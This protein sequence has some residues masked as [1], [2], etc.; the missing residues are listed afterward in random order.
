MKSGILDHGWDALER[1]GE[2]SASFSQ[3]TEEK[4][5]CGSLELL[6]R[7]RRMQ[8]LLR[9]LEWLRYEEE[10]G[11][12]HIQGWH[13]SA[14]MH[15]AT[16]G[17]KGKMKGRYCQRAPTLHNLSMQIELWDQPVAFG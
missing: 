16:I 9:Q 7:S 17:R 10:D 1:R 4:I 6:S 8:A 5:G 13:C 2:F 3:H 11:A 15:I 12:N 14:R